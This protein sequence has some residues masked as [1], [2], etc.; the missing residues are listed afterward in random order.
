M[1]ISVILSIY[2]RSRLLGRALEGYLW[3]TMPKKDFEI[4]LVDDLSTEDLSLA[5][6]DV[7]G[8]L[9][10]RHVRMDHTRHSIFKA[11]NPDWKPGMRKDWFHTPALSTNIGTHLA[12]GRILCL[13]HPE[14][15]HGPA[16]FEYAEHRL[17][18]ERVFLFGKTYLG[19][20]RHNEWLDRVSWTDRG[21]PG[22]LQSIFAIDI[23]KSF[24][25]WEFY[26][27]T[28]FVPKE[29]VVKVRGVDFTYLNGVQ[30]EDDDLRE[31][32]RRAGCPPVHAPEIQGFHQDHS[33]ETELHHRRDLP[34]WEEASK[35][36]RAVF[37]GRRD[38]DSFPAVNE[39]HDWT[40]AECVVSETRYDLGETR[41]KEV[42]H[43]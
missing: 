19:T 18:R 42:S 17:E 43:A 29:A 39:E 41:G 16:N 23:P 36:N 40:A 12:Q 20:P 4:V 26:W 30:A 8:R 34:I 13:C 6:K 10:L 11:R 3:Q 35:R 21:W 25:P 5:Y 15:L 38:R 24:H 28:S 37:F 33:H 31:R 22:L 32:L 7:L 2:N 1:I 9:N 27:Y 14:I